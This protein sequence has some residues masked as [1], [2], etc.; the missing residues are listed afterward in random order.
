MRKNHLPAA[1]AAADTAVAD[2]SEKLHIQ[3][4]Q[5]GCALY[6]STGWQKQHYLSVDSPKAKHQEYYYYYYYTRRSALKRPFPTRYDE[7]VDAGILTGV[8]LTV[9]GRCVVVMFHHRYHFGWKIRFAECFAVHF[10]IAVCPS[11]L[12][13]PPPP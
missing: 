8:W 5:I 13:I 10:L 6:Y 4:G 1:A 2:D 7:D 9:G 11:R 12:S 3:A